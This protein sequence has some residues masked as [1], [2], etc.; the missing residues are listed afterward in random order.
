MKTAAEIREK[1][2][3]LIERD[4]ARLQKRCKH[5]TKIWCDQQWAPAHSTGRDVLVCD[6]C[7]KILEERQGGSR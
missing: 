1:Y 7:G 3:K 5:P 6:C 2:N 4:L